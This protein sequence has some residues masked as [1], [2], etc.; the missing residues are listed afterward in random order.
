METKVNYAIVGLFVIVV[1]AIAFI[2]L[3]WLS[4]GV[5]K[6]TY[7]PYLVYIQ[8][9]VSGLSLD[10]PVKYNGVEVGKVKEIHLRKDNPEQVIVLLDIEQGTPITTDTFA[11]L[12]AQSLTGI[13]YLELSGG[14]PGSPPLK[15]TDDQ[16]YPVIQS[17]PSLMF[18]VDAAIS[19][20]TVNADE[21][22][23]SIKK[24][25]NKENLDAFQ[26]IL[27]NLKAVSLELGKNA[28]KFDLIINDSQKTFANTAKA[29]EKFTGTL[30]KIDTAA[31]SFTVMVK[32]F[33]RIGQESRTT[34]ENTSVAL[35]NLNDDLIPQ[36]TDVVGDIQ[37]MTENLKQLSQQLEQNPSVIIRGRTPSP[38]GPG[39]RAS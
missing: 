21:V 12:D 20:V 24:L 15:A 6:K 18:R 10:S 8:E 3:L 5:S 2:I 33:T 26:T 4:V 1:T 22:A 37:A 28:Q 34:F 11:E 38:P 19:R 9:S 14:K 17:K 36:V 23:Q 16:E 7:T 39:E 35:K 27:Q 31:D 25:L 32:D 13:A 29:S 30:G